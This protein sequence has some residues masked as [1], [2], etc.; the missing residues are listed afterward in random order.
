MDKVRAGT[1]DY[2]CIEIM[3]CP[4][5]CVGG[6]GQP[7]PTNR[8]VRALRGAALYLDD[9]SVQK[10]RQSHE[11]PSIKKA[12]DTFLKEPLG[13]KSHKLLHTSYTDR[14]VDLPHK[15]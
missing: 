5:G 7:I 8:Q 4:G 3:A 6:G 14:G 15:G 11:N 10:H 2:H 12:Y 9:G 1:A 13:H